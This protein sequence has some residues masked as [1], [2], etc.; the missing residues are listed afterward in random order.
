MVSVSV[1]AGL[2]RSLQAAWQW[3]T[4]GEVLLLVTGGLQLAVPSAGPSGPVA[5]RGGGGKGAVAC[6]SGILAMHLLYK[7]ARRVNLG[8]FALLFGA[9]T[10]VAALGAVSD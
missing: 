2:E 6:F 8:Y 4:L 10:V 7:L 3:V 5:G 9:L 1:I